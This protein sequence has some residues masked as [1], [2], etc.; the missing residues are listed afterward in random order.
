M[1]SHLFCVAVMLTLMA[2]EGQALGLVR[3]STDSTANGASPVAPTTPPAAATPS[4]PQMGM[5]MSIPVKKPMVMN[6]ESA[7]QLLSTVAPLVAGRE[8]NEVE[9]LAIEQNAHLAIEPM[10]REWTQSKSIGALARRLI[11]TKFAVGGTRAGINFELPGNLA[12]YVAENKLPWSTLLTADYCVSNTGAKTTCDTGAPFSGGGMLN[13]RAFLSSRAG[14]FNLTRAST[15]LLGFACEHYPM[16][17]AIEPRLDAT[18]L[19]ALFASNTPPPDFRD[20][21]GNNS[22]CYTC[23]SQFG[24]HAQFFVKFNEAGQYDASADGVQD[25][26]GEPGRSRKVGLMAS[27]LLEPM[28]ANESSQMLGKPAANLAEAAAALARNRLFDT[29]QVGNV[30]DALVNFRNGEQDSKTKDDIVARATALGTVEP[31]FGD[32]VFEIL[33][34]PRIQKAFLKDLGVLK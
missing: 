19:T 4:G 31:T 2:C 33:T 9:L 10:V 1:K 3:Q 15:M 28:S 30:I 7:R 24:A 29:C 6:A 17:P 12:A 14:R 21:V 23:H 5:P 16:D 11:Q 25:P 26:K 20:G 13:T 32:L 22:G 18:R 8:L 27:H 34:E